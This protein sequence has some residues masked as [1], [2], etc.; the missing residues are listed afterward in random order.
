MRNENG[1]DMGIWC[2]AEKYRIKKEI[3]IYEEV[4]GNE[5]EREYERALDIYRSLIKL[6][7][8]F[9]DDHTKKGLE[10]CISLQKKWICDHSGWKKGGVNG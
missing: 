5:R 8:K 10:E 6:K 3:K 4:L 2:I 1:Y 9:K 7:A